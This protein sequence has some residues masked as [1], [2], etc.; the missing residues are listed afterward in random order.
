M[1]LITWQLWLARDLVKDLHLPMQKPQT[2]LTPERTAQS[3]FGLLI[4]I[5]TPAVPPKT[6]GKSPGW[7]PGQ[8]R[9][10]RKTYPTVKKRQSRAKKS[11]QQAA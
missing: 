10:K 11:Q 8:K 3:I 2:H 4:E 5:G 6:R 7:Q 9:N 1:P